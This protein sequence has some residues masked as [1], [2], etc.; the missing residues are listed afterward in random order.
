MPKPVPEFIRSTTCSGPL[1]AVPCSSAPQN[2]CQSERVVEHQ[3]WSP[4]RA[5]RRQ[6]TGS[7]RDI[8]NSQRCHRHQTQSGLPF[9]RFAA[10]V[11][12]SCYM[13]GDEALLSMDDALYT[14]QSQ[15]NTSTAI[16]PLFR[17]NNPSPT[18]HIPAHLCRRTATKRRMCSTAPFRSPRRWHWQ[19]HKP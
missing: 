10:R 11:V 6:T 2:P 19:H 13:P 8:A 12:N 4:Y 16:T 18:H 17:K 1:D 5:K 9:M 15:R 3:N 14:L 7:K